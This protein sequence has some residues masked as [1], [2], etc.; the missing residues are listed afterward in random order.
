MG[1][2]HDYGNPHDYRM[3][4]SYQVSQLNWGRNILHVSPNPWANPKQLVD[5]QDTKGI[6]SSIEMGH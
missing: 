2:P 1:Y 3:S 6:F 4:I 5:L